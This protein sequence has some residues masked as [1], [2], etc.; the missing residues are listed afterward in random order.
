MR[1]DGK[2]KLLVPKACVPMGSRGMPH[3]KIMKICCSRKYP[4][5]YSPHGKIFVLHPLTPQE[6]PGHLHTFLLKFGF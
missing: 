2:D 3:Q 1:G 4:D 5:R 6:I